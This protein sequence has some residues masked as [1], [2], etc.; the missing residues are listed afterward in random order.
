MLTKLFK[1]T[2]SHIQAKLPTLSYDLNELEPVLSQSAMDIHYNK[3]HQ[4]YIN[5]YNKA[6]EAL[7]N[8]EAKGNYNDVLKFTDLVKFHLGGHFNHSFFWENLSPI[9]KKGGVLP[10]KEQQFGKIVTE[11]FGSFDKLVAEVSRVA[12]TTQGSGW[13]WL[14]WN[15]NIHKLVVAK[16]ANQDTLSQQ[17]VTPLLTLDLWEHAYYINYQNKRAAYI[18]EVWKVVNW[19]KVEERFNQTQVATKK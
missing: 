11:H 10:N 3:H 14:G 9:N 18:D 19:N 17:G 7:L 6:M 16:T 5:E 2:F 13:V 4:T 8:A 12:G 15:N 1:K